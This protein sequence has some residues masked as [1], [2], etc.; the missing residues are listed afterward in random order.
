AGETVTFLFPSHKAY[1]YYGIE[2]K[3]GTNVPVQSTVTLKSIN[4]T[5]NN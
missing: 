4:S 5:E 2:N 3:L 1:G